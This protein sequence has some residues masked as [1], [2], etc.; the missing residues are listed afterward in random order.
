MNRHTSSD[1][2]SFPVQAAYDVRPDSSDVMYQISILCHFEPG[3]VRI[4]VLNDGFAIM[5]QDKV[6][7]LRLNVSVV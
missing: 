3:A 4:G 1:I 2:I 7:G 6:I 5:R